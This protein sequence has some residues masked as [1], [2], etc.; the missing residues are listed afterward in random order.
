MRLMTSRVQDVEKDDVGTNIGTRIALLGIRS[1]KQQTQMKRMAQ[2]PDF[3]IPNCS[4]GSVTFMHDD[5][6][7]NVVAILRDDDASCWV[8]Q[9]PMKR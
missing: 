2:H 5:F 8:T 9:S 7:S 1:L 4:P 6:D 3:F